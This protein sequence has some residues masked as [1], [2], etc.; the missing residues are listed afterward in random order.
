LHQINQEDDFLISLKNNE[1]VILDGYHFNEK[2]Q[3]NIKSTGAKLI[4]IDVLVTG[5]Q[6]ADLIINLAPGVKNEDYFGE[7]HTQYL[8]GPNFA[9][10]RQVFLNKI[11]NFLI[12]SFPLM[13]HEVI[14]FS[15]KSD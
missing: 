7:P 14:G 12:L 9:L 2:Y 4:Y 8:L 15:K 1:L 11:P 3:R 10:V 13:T 5:H 6:V